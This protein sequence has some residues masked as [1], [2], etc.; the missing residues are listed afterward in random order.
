MEGWTCIYTTTFIHEAELIRW[1]LEENM[2][3]AFVVNKQDSAYLIGDIEIH[4]PNANAF[5]AI[6][7][8]KS[9]KSE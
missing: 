8:I 9:D 2:I 3:K 5:E 4:V 6:Q 1:M 7:L